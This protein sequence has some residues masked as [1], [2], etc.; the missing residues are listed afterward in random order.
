MSKREAAAERQISTYY[1]NFFENDF[2]PVWITLNRLHWTAF[3]K[4]LEE[5]KKEARK[6]L[7]K[8]EWPSQA[9]G[10]SDNSRMTPTPALKSPIETDRD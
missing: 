6:E 7:H 5:A 10:N 1:K 4:V 8:G 2:P 9:K 3:S